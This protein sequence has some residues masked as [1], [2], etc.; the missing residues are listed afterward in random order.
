M[1]S[2]SR[3]RERYFRGAKG[4]NAAEGLAVCYSLND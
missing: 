4:D 1:F 3:L 2:V